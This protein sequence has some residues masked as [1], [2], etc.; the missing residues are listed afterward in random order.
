LAELDAKIQVNHSKL[1][2]LHERFER[3]RFQVREK[4]DEEKEK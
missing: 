3:I 4:L 2:E 1:D